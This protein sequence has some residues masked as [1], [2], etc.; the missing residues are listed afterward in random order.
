M[1][2]KHLLIIGAKGGLANLTIKKLLKKYPRL[3]ITGIDTRIL[4]TPVKSSRYNYKLLEYKRG[5]FENLFRENTFDYVLYLSRVT[6]SSISNN[7]LQKRL[8]LSVQGTQT[9]LDLALQN[10]VQKMIIL[11]SFHVYGALNDNPIF[12]EERFP[13]RGS[14]KFPELRDVV[15]MDQRCEAWMH[16]NKEKLDCIILRP[17]NIIGKNLRNG[18]T[19]YLTHPLSFFPMDYNPT[20]QFIHEEDMASVLVESLKVQPGLYNV[21]PPGYV[22]I[23]DAVLQ[24]N[25]HAYSLPV[26]ALSRINSLV[27]KKLGVPGYLLD[28]LKYPCLLSNDKF[29]K[30]FKNI[31]L[32]YDVSKA[33]DELKLYLDEQD[34]ELEA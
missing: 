16:E 25:P 27:N 22:S 9:I 18:I 17:T 23:K 14:L 29:Q 24:V 7:L 33:L 26:F 19:N 10:N 21:T 13:L 34:L 30:G 15:E 11:S 1:S 3:K 28:Y 20:V 8:N 4:E 32:K 12:L 2:Q 5:D 31:I 6:H